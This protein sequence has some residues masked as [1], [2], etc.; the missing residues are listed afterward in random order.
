MYTNRTKTKLFLLPF[1]YV[2]VVLFQVLDL[3]NT[4]IDYIPL[5]TFRGLNRIQMIDLSHNRFV[6]VPDSLSLIGS[7]LQYLT[8]NDNDI[9]ELNDDSFIGIVLFYF[10]I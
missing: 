8:F 1:V 4:D 5:D 9:V 7:S 3:S 10:T 6:T 2:M